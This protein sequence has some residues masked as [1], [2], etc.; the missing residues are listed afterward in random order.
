MLADD[1]FWINTGYWMCV[2]VC[3]SEYVGTKDRDAVQLYYGDVGSS[4]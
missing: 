2:C 3:G 1:L 4:V